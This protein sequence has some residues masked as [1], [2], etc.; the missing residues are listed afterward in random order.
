MY[1]MPHMES[2][3]EAQHYSPTETVT[4]SGLL[5]PRTDIEIGMLPVGRSPDSAPQ[6]A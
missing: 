4:P 3:S 5:Y 1:D 6:A 2:D